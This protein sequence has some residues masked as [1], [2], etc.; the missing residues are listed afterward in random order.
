MTPDLEEAARKQREAK[1]RQ[2]LADAGLTPHTPTHQ[3][4]DSAKV[5]RSL[6]TLNLL[7]AAL[8]LL[9]AIQLG[10]Q[11]W[12]IVKTRAAMQQFEKATATAAS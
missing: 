2:K 4:D 5:V 6:G 10:I 12:G 1:A 8:V 11:L 9:S 7:V 3:D